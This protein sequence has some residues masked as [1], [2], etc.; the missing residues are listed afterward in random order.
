MSKKKKKKEI[1]CFCV[2]RSNFFSSLFFFL[3]GLSLYV[4]NRKKWNLPQNIRIEVEGARF[5][6]SMLNLSK[7]DNSTVH[8][9]TLKSLK[10]KLRIKKKIARKKKGSPV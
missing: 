4:K 8:R 9:G 5:Y 1:L 6:S 10:K 7:I 3:L 2:A